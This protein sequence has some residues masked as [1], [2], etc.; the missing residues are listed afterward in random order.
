MNWYYVD[1]GAQAGPVQEA[2]L[3]QLHASGKIQADT[4]VWREGLANWIPYREVKGMG[5][6][7]AGTATATE[8]NTTCTECGASFPADHLLRYGTA[9][10]CANCKPVFM[11]KLAE[12]AKLNSGGLE[13]AGVG[14]RFGAIILDGI[15]LWLVGTGIQFAI[16]AIISK[17][18][19]D[20]PNLA[21]QFVLMGAQIFLAVVYETAMIGRYGATL[22]KMACKIKVVT[23][24]GGQVSYLRALGR[25]FAKYISQIICLFG[26]IMA[27]FD[28]EERRTLHDRI[29]NTRVVVR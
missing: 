2:Q 25:H 22:G 23:A 10:V 21:L 27:L 19:N 29:C 1:Q 28:K 4:L 14:T 9:R 16:G 26:Y 11:Q 6:G 24:D 12:G 3:E 20:T 18:P 13:Y 8:P 7:P 17:G 5:A 15:L